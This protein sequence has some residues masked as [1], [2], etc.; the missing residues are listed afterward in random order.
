MFTK[1][2]CMR[3]IFFFLL[4]SVCISET[5]QS[6]VQQVPINGCIY[7]GYFGCLDAEPGR[8]NH[9]L[10]AGGQSGLFES[11][12]SGHTWGKIESLPAYA[13]ISVSFCPRDAN[14]I[15]V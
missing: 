4:F 12:D 6:Q 13:L 14:V 1:T 11:L 9:V 5:A 7:G 8:P 10:A 2:G 15:I 3:M